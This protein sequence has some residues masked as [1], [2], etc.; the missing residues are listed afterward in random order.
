[1]DTERGPSRCVDTNPVR[2]SRVTSRRARKKRKAACKPSSVFAVA[3]GGH[4]S[5]PDVADRLE[6]PTRGWTGLPTPPIWPCSGWG[7]HGS[8][9]YCRDGELLPHLFTLTRRSGRFVSVAL[10]VG[11]PRP[12]VSGHPVRWSSDFPLPLLAVEAA[13]AQPPCNLIVGAENRGCQPGV[14]STD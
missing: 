5:R 1:M 2:S 7:L 14:G 9:H 4:P 6:R 12:A 3:N 8:Q 11:S 10:S 13:T